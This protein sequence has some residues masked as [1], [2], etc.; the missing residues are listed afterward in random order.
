MRVET[1]NACKLSHRLWEPAP[2]GRETERAGDVRG[3][4][5]A[6]AGEAE[7]TSGGWNP[8]EPQVVAGGVTGATPAA[9]GLRKSSATDRRGGWLQRIVRR[10]WLLSWVLSIGGPQ[11][12]TP[13]EVK[14]CA[15]NGG[16]KTPEED[17]GTESDDEQRENKKSKWF[18]LGRSS[19]KQSHGTANNRC[20]RES[21]Q[22]PKRSDDAG[23]DMRAGSAVT[24]KDSVLT[25]RVE[26]P[27]D[28]KLSDCGGRRSLCGKVAGVG[29]RAG[30]QAVT[31]GAV[32]CSAWLAVAASLVVAVGIK[33]AMLR[34]SVACRE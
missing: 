12:R 5:P 21:N 34:E 27:N 29:L 15:E 31:P 23:I 19:G 10:R 9:V 28:P 26:S 13:P 32:R 17:S 1:P 20:D 11:L 25:M 2:A 14:A 6:W 8:G 16:N 18:S 3:A 30:A 4:T 24:H 22:N 33:S 7:G